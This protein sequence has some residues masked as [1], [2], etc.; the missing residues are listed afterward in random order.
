MKIR[1]VIFTVLFPTSVVSNDIIFLVVESDVIRNTT[2][3]EAKY[4]T[5]VVSFA[6]P[7]RFIIH[8][9]KQ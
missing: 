7:G 9:L 6:T 3:V 1:E 2:S 5:R 4:Y 8:V